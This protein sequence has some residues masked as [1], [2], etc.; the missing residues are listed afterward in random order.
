MNEKKVSVI[1]PAYNCGKYICEAIESVLNQTYQ[2]REIIVV[3]DG[4]TDN[5]KDVLKWYILNRKIKYVHQENR[6]PSGARNRAIA[7]SIGEFIGFLDADDKWLNEKLEKSINFMLQNGFD[8]MCSSMIKL[9]KSN[10]EIVK[11]IP[12]DSW[13]INPKTRE[14]KQLKNGLFFF[15]SIP[16][17]TPTIVAKR[18]CFEKVGDFDEK[19][20]IGED[21]DLWLRFEEA[22]LRGGYLDEPLTIYRYNEKSIT[23][24]KKVDGV[25]EH[26]KVAKKHAIILGLH[27]ELIKKSYGGFLWQVADRYYSDRQIV[28]AMRYVLKSIYYDPS[29]LLK[30]FRKF[31][32]SKTK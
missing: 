10:E 8:W 16:V 13:V 11:R 28:K 19:F 31:L 9:T 15:S 1:I 23:K 6:G 27:N 7:E 21:T 18:E 24:N 32:R 26:A 25:A 14:I 22:G 30:I 4:S 5:T 3:D 29:Y 20:L 12:D 2:D 17:H